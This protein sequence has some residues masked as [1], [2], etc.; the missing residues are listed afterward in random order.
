M[1]H[2]IERLYACMPQD[3]RPHIQKLP[4]F[5]YLSPLDGLPQLLA[6]RDYC[7]PPDLGSVFDFCQ[8]LEQRLQSTDKMLAIVTS[9]EGEHCANTGFLLGAYILMIL[10]KDL[11]STMLCLHPILSNAQHYMSSSRQTAGVH[12]RVQDCLGALQRAKQIGWVDFTYSPNRFDVD[13]YRQLDSPLNA[14]LHV[15]VPEKLILMSGPRDLPGGA[16]W[17]DIPSEDGRSGRREFSPE[18]YA[19]ILVQLDVQ[20][21]LR[22]S[23]PTY[24]SKGFETAGIAVV[25][26]CCEDDAPPPVDVV[27]KFLAVV[28]RLPGAVAVHCGSG[29]GRSGTLVALYLMKHHGFTAREAMGWLRIVR[30]GWY[31][32]AVLCFLFAFS[33][34]PS[35]QCPSICR[36]ITGEQQ[37][38]F[39]CAKEPVMRLSAAALRAR[40]PA[41]AISLPPQDLE[42]VKAAVSA[43][44]LEV[45]AKFAAVCTTV[46]G[47]PMVSPAPHRLGSAPNLGARTQGATPP[48][49]AIEKQ[50]WPGGAGAASSPFLSAQFKNATGVGELHCKVESV[51]RT[52]IENA[53]A[54]SA[55][56]PV[57]VTR[58]RSYD[59]SAAGM[60]R[61]C[62][63]WAAT[64]TPGDGSVRRTWLQSAA[65]PSKWRSL[66]EISAAALAEACAGL[67]PRRPGPILVSGSRSGMRKG[68]DSLAAPTSTA[69]AQLGAESRTAI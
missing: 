67:S 46:L 49:A 29:R 68:G 45:D 27:S 20:A 11:E 64:C 5:D 60:G 19:D 6:L 63:T 55:I 58:S 31:A 42:A 59:V 15:V 53:S 61:P 65:T 51:F 7:G 18:H 28:E 25:D 22:C 32:H 66:P 8:A 17:R 36:S 30:P 34:K 33:W 48:A 44:V 41:P 16:L 12:L 9:N 1:H 21:V 57:I 54:G 56:A 14:D 50:P 47:S 4:N 52:S 26:L 40:A 43:A 10:K 13:E 3:D 37:Q 38:A 2:I 69:A 24:D 23:T 62:L 35:L 39:L